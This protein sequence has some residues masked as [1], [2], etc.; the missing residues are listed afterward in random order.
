MKDRRN[1][2]IVITALLALSVLLYGG[3]Y[4]LFPERLTD[5]GFY[6]LLDIAFIPLNVVLVGLVIDRLLAARERTAL[7][8]KMN[9]VVG[10]FFSEMGT[11]L[12]DRLTR[13]DPD[14]ESLRPHLVFTPRW[15]P[16]DYEEAQRQVSTDSHPMSLSCG[17]IA[18]LRAFM[19]ENRSFLLRLLENPNLLEHQTFTDAL[20]AVTHLA[21]E[22]AARSD[23]SA[24]PPSDVRHVELDMARAYGR[25]L[26]EWL[27]YVRHLK[28][29]Y[30][31][32]FS[33]A[34]R[35]NPFDRDASIEVRE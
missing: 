27:G 17:D 30:P 34:V 15:T 24:M 3:L 21:E 29:D 22:L 10:A 12:V 16:A 31:Y 9:M 26:S 11:E 14:V 28:A 25:L 20:W 4:V 2:W 5:I 23:L 8:H 1:I 18:D 13:F 6:T 35:T 19:I 7:L 33:F 32:L